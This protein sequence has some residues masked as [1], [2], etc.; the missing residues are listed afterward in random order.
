MVLYKR[1]L[2]QNWQIINYVLTNLVEYVFLQTSKI[3]SRN[4]RMA[5]VSR[6][7]HSRRDYC[8]TSKP[9][10]EKLEEEKLKQLEGQENLK[11]ENSQENLKQENS[12]EKPKQE[13]EQENSEEKCSKCGSCLNKRKKDSDSDTDSDSSSDDD[14][15]FY[16]S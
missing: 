3:M 4:A 16:M 9:K 10:K 14:D 6:V 1:P 5:H 11:Q 13:K 12:Q 15:S 8:L 7:Q 2:P